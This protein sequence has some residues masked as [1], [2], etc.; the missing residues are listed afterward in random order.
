MAQ[1]QS[2]R[3]FKVR[4]P[5]PTLDDLR[6]RINATRWPDKETVGD[7]SQGMQLAEMRDPVRYWGNGYD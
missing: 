4:V 6:R 7:R 1:D 5:Q 2:L 3:P